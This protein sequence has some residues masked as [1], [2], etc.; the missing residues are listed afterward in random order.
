MYVAQIVEVRMLSAIA[1]MLPHAT[2]AGVHEWLMQWTPQANFKAV[3]ADNEAAAIEML[4]IDLIDN[5]IRPRMF[6]PEVT[7]Q[8]FEF[9]I[10]GQDT[11]HFRFWM[12]SS[13]SY[14]TWHPVRRSEL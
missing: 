3:I 14:G 5:L 7:P 13:V 2:Y 12:P 8:M 6:P 1:G 4:R 9:R 10:S 11:V